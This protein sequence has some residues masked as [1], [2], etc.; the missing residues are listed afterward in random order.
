MPGPPPSTPC[1]R[2][3]FAIGTQTRHWVRFQQTYGSYLPCVINVTELFR[4]GPGDNTRTTG[5]DE[6]CRRRIRR[7][8]LFYPILCIANVLLDMYEI[9]I[10]LCR[11]GRH[12]SLT[13]A[14]ELARATGATL[15]APC[16]RSMVEGPYMHPNYL[17]AYIERYHSGKLEACRKSPFPI[18]SVCYSDLVWDGRS[19][20]TKNSQVLNDY[21]SVLK[22]DLIMELLPVTDSLGWIYSVIGRSTWV[23]DRHYW[24]SD[25]RYIPPCIL[26][27][28]AVWQSYI[29]SSLM[30]EL[31]REG[32]GT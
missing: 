23:S 14:Y 25:R 8:S 6:E 30:L 10:V 21:H 32:L 19:W 7:M 11:H 12:R 22:G 5:F 2:V 16:H 15:V 3:V 4:R 27:H 13:V 17:V 26:N 20:V 28:Y 24:V 31:L 29:S 1:N 18:V 9:V